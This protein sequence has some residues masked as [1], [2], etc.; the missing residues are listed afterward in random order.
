MMQIT[1]SQIQTDLSKSLSSG[2]YKHTV[3]VA[4]TAKNL[5]LKFGVDPQKAELAG[6]LHDLAKEYKNDDLLQEA[7]R[8]RLSL[9]P[10]DIASP[11]LLH[12][13]VGA[14]LAEEKYG[15]DDRAVLDAIAQHTLGRPLMSPLEEILFVADAI[16]PSRSPLWADPIKERLESAGLKAAVLKCCQSTIEEVVK[17]GFLLHP[18]TVETY[19]FYLKAI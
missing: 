3:G 13:R 12:A 5:A 7:A 17:K 14:C 1:L 11:H 8:F 10:I 4:E 19:N 6:W 18:L 16:E 9:H 2:R 15:V